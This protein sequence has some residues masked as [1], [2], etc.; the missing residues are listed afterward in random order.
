MDKHH[1]GENK[2]KNNISTIDNVVCKPTDLTGLMTPGLSPL[3]V[4]NPGSDIGQ[5]RRKA[6]VCPGCGKI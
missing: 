1:G 2:E 4:I 6:I 3:G 5:A